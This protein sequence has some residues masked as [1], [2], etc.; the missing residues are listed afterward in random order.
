[1]IGDL[2]SAYLYAKTIEKVYFVCGPEWGTYAGC[3]AIVLKTVY[4]LVGSAH[5]YHRHV[6][7]VVQS[8]GWKPALGAKDIWRRLDKENKLYDYI[9]FYADDFIIVS[10]H[11]AELATELGEIFFK[12]IGPPS[13]YLGA[14]DRLADGYYQFASSTYLAEVLDQLQ[15]AESLEEVPLS[16]FRKFKTPF[17]FKE[18]DTTPLSPGDHPEEDTLELLDDVGNHI[19]QRMAGILQWIVLI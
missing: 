10:H 6:F 8:L 15:R 3:I 18:N 16:G 14:D 11:L 4:G 9:A 12:E 1:M 5:A 17:A 13:R 19:Y 2:A 7:D